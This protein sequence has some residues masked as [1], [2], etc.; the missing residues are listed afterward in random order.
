MEIELK[1]LLKD[2]A[3]AD[4]IFSDE[5]VKQAEDEKS[6]ETIDMHSVYYDT[7][8]HDLTEAG[9]A[10]RVRKEGDLYVATM[11]DRGESAEGM[12]RREEI[13]VRLSDD[14]MITSPELSIFS[15]SSEYERILGI[16][17]GKKLVP[18]LEMKFE[19]RQVR[20][21]T[22]G[23]ISELSADDGRIIA[24][25]KSLPLMELE[26]E[27]Y[28]GS[29]QDMEDFGRDLAERYGLVPEDKSKFQRGYELAT[30]RA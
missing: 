26:L 25:E 30:G 16:T 22:G 23:S 18:V 24:G 15:E 20:L 27:L 29:E 13:N 21:D 19:R 28:S 2:R 5:A 6:F 8:A 11:K 4:R 1:Y 9:I 7:A 12:H 17:G 14:R 3:Q 10:V